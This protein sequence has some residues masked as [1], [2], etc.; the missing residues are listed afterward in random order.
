[1]P[2]S[3]F[4]KGSGPTSGTRVWAVRSAAIAATIGL[5]AAAAPV[6]WQAVSAGLGVAALVALGL[7]GAVIFQALPWGLQR[8]ENHL[9]ARRK[10]EAR[11]HPIEQLQNEVQRRAE[12]LQGFRR[13][14]A[15]V[16][17]QI[18]SIG[19]M[20]DERRP[21][22][23]S[24]VLAR[25]QRALD[26]LVQFHAVNLRRLDDAQMA[27]GQFRHTVEQKQAE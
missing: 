7:C 14:L 19:E 18:Q 15:T 5:L 1:M 22:D 23:P 2:M 6:L 13:S 20:L 3:S 26:R 24:P 12:R 17:G 27:L 11:A 4:S 16:G 21:L 8:L 10:A 9:L 25:Q